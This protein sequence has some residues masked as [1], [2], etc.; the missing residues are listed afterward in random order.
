MSIIPTFLRA[1]GQGEC[2]NVQTVRITH[3]QDRGPLLLVSILV[4]QL[5]EASEE[6]VSTPKIMMLVA[7][8]G[9]GRDRLISGT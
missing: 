6:P 8:R 5:N 7:A 9:S 3:N 2:D 1:E 4:Q